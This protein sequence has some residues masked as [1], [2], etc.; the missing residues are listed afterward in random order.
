MKEHLCPHCGTDLTKGVIVLVPT[1]LY[2]EEYRYSMCRECENFLLVD[3]NNFKVSEL[4]G[5]KSEFDAIKEF[6]KIMTEEELK[7]NSH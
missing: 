3:L 4:N 7:D 1:T 6:D 2:D 5:E